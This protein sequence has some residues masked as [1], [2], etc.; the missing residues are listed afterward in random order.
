MLDAITAATIATARYLLVLTKDL[1]DFSLSPAM[2]RAQGSLS[3]GW[4]VQSRP[5]R[6]APPPEMKTHFLGNP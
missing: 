6:D 2:A 4:T 3:E 1:L 5:W